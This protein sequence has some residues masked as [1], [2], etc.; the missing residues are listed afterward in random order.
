MN[1]HLATAG[2][3][4]LALAFVVVFFIGRTES[5]HLSELAP[6]TGLSYEELV[7]IAPRVA[8]QTG[9]TLGTSRHVVY[10]LACSG[11]A[12]KSSFEMQATQASSLARR[13]RL[14]DREAVGAVLGPVAGGNAT[15]RLKDC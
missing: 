12:D 1:K 2:G 8:S 14:T 5:K 15:N 10:L 3:L 9:A 11:L 13:Q 4:V 6:R 7:A